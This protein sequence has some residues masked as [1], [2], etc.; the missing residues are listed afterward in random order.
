[1]AEPKK[2]VY[3]ISIRFPDFTRPLDRL[4]DAVE[5]F[6]SIT[7]ALYRL[8]ELGFQRWQTLQHYKIEQAKAEYT[9][10]LDVVKAKNEEEF[11]KLKEAGKLVDVWLMSAGLQKIN[12]IKAIR[13]L[14]DLGLKEAKD[15]AD[16]APCLITHNL[17]P[18]MAQ[19]Y[20]KE[21]NE[22]GGIV[23]IRP[24]I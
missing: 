13:T 20:R 14:T 16:R 21:I 23:E 18:D 7:S 6:M 2:I 10:Q 9:V 4:M 1:M 17:L 24:Q 5:R 11:E 22:A 8:G 15:I 19:R 12:V 3:D